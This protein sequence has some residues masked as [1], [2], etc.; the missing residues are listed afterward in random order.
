[1]H[2]PESDVLKPIG[3]SVSED[4]W[5]E[6]VLSD[7]SVVYE[8]SG[9][10]ANLLAAYADVPLKVQGRL[11]SPP[12]G[13]SDCLVKKPYKP[14]DIV[15]RNVTRYAYAEFPDKTFVIWAL[16][17]AGWF[18]IQP[19]PQYK[20]IYDDMVQAV[21]LL[22]F[23]T[24][25]YNEPRKR[26]GGPSA[27]LI[28]REYAEDE[29]SACTNPAEAEQIFHKHRNFLLMS[30]LQRTNSIGWS[31]TPLYQTMRRQFPNDFETCKARHEGRFADIKT[32][33]V[34][35]TRT[36]PAPATTARP[37]SEKKQPNKGKTSVTRLD[38][39]PKKDDNWWEASVL[40]EFMQKA[41]NQRVI[42]AGRNSI[43]VER[44]AQ[45]I[46]KRYEI[47]NVETARNVLLVH[48]QNL[49]YM[50]D[51]PRRQ[52]IRFFAAEP[53]Y[54]ELAA[55]HGL[56]AAE[57]RRAQ[58]VEL[59]PRKDHGTLRGEESESSDTSDEEDDILSTPVRRLPGRSKKG[60]LSV[61]RPR[62]G[63]FS[64]KGK[65]VDRGG[66]GKTKPPI[67]VS[68]SD[69]E[70][71]SHNEDTMTVNTPIHTLSPGPAKRKLD[72][73]DE[74]TEGK[75]KRAHSSPTALSSPPTSGDETP[76]PGTVDP[77]PLRYHPGS[78]QGASKSTQPILPAI[79]STPLPTY[80]SNGPRDSWIC[81]FDGCGQKIY[82]CS[83]EVG[84][85]LITEHLEDH[86]KGRE[87]VVGILW[88][89][90]DRLNLPVE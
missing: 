57:Q 59:R 13:R 76:Q 58:G 81:S 16:G 7:A 85:Q 64:G 71:A 53:I 17:E 37:A 24:D 34:S 61:L 41:V 44:V 80:E 73:L 84:R 51:H 66:K 5:P 55:G 42:R 36:S 2:I 74:M 32:E 43:T 50:M 30:F 25:I 56:S 87:K 65:S 86:T 20:A 26:G 79:V 35:R 49:C 47:D 60:T 3:P 27:S 39:P 52:N 69:S 75:R 22:Y 38:E 88:Q 12:R 23:V 21:Q 54:G 31:N 29:R 8:N 89:E 19:Q 11:Q 82:G 67:P 14:T 40:F 68:D 45:L 90:Q 10:P 9:K 1:M 28:Y 83:K 33:R 4:A 72:I 46:I 62:S 78:T 18:E 15:V 63:K 70:S 48:A 6:F 77:L